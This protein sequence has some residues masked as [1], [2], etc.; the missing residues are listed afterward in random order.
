MAY[1]IINGH[2]ILESDMLPKTNF[3]QPSRKCKGVK[4]PECQLMEPFS[5]IDNVKA[6]FFYALPKI[7][8]AT[9]TEALAKAPSIDAFKNNL[10]K[11]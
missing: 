9:V 10:K 3:K 6:T 8:N 1:K 7:W 11:F 5:K 2:V 4:F